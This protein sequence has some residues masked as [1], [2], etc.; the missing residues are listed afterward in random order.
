MTTLVIGAA[1]QIGRMIVSKLHERGEPVIAM[2]RKPDAELEALGVEIRFADLEQDFS[3]ALAGCDQIIFTAGSGAKTG[4]DKTILVDMWGAIKL[5]D[6]AKQ[7]GV[8]QFVMVSS[9]GAED[10]DNGPAAI[11]H[12]SV[13]KKI[14][15]DY[16]LASGVNYTILRPGR[17]LN[18][19]ATGGFSTTMPDTKDAQIITREDVA[20]ACIYCLQTSG[21]LN[22]IYPLVN[23]D[24]PLTESLI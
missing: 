22:K 7:A 24:Q 5:V 21:T 18:E 14:A 11:K 6:A 19:P 13:C 9:R 16:L 4:A 15:D 3:H 17:L 12:Y 1:G 2:L 20:D 10:P 23:G 8:K